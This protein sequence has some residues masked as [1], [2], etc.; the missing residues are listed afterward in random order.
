LKTIDADLGDEAVS[1]A[2]RHGN[3]VDGV[4]FSTERA[5]LVA[6]IL[7]MFDGSPF[8][9][10]VVFGIDFEVRKSCLFASF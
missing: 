2:S 7:A 1:R 5:A 3:S 9:G 10:I 4:V 8:N 6:I